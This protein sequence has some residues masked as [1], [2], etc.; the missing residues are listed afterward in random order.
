MQPKTTT[1]DA[2]LPSGSVSLAFPPLFSKLSVIV[3]ARFHI[4][5]RTCMYLLVGGIGRERGVEMGGIVRM[6]SIKGR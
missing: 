6:R 3:C 1:E 2:T 5:P 4:T